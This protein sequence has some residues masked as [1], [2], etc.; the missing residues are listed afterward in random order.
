VTALV[1]QPPDSESRVDEFIDAWSTRYPDATH[2]LRAWVRGHPRAVALLDAWEND[3]RLESATE[4]A[5]DHP[6]ENLSGL[7]FERRGWVELDEAV[8]NP[9]S[10][11]LDAY[12]AWCRRYPRA[13]RELTARPHAFER[14]AT[15]AAPQR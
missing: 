9:L 14:F 12:A 6:Y 2:A 3:I 10:H 5:I 1:T 4:W 8:S 7:F 11:A 13:A 15:S